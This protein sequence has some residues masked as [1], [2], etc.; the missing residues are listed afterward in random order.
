MNIILKPEEEQLIE[1]KVKSGRYETAYE[2]II[3]ALQLLE[4][5]DKHYERWI[6]EIHK[7]VA[8]ALKQLEGRSEIEREVVITRLLDQLISED[9]DPIVIEKLKVLAQKHGRSLQAELKQIIEAAVPAQT[10]NQ[11]DEKAVTK[12]PEELGWSPGFFERTAGCFQDEP[13]VR[14]PQGELQERNWDDLSAGFLR[15]T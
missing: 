1:E 4:E 2:V 8:V 11:P 13:L 7:E 6:E 3:E 9:S 14:Y 5:R 10:L 12:T 15:I